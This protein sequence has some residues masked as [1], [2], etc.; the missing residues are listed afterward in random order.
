MAT[1]PPFCLFLDRSLS[2]VQVIIHSS[3]SSALCF[4]SCYTD[5]MFC[6][7]QPFKNQHCIVLTYTLNNILVIPG[8]VSC[9]SWSM[10]VESCF[11]QNNNFELEN[12]ERHCTF[13]TLPWI[14]SLISL[15]WRSTVEWAICSES[16]GHVCHT[17][18]FKHECSHKWWMLPNT[19]HMLGWDL[20]HS[21][22]LTIFLRMSWWVRAIFCHNWLITLLFHSCKADCL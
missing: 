22:C 3:S 9:Q 14:N 2:F 8:Q 4:V 6:N 11:C 15:R 17:S 12:V 18:Q 21:R 20:L 19:H 13:I 7:C 5:S 1:C 10:F 16:V